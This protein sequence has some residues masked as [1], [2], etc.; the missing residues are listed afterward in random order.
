MKRPAL[1]LSTCALLACGAARSADTATVPFPTRPIRLVVPLTSG[2]I[3]DVMSR[4]LA[5]KLK[6]SLGQAVVVENR[7]GAGTMLA[8]EYVARADADGYTLLM[9]ASSLTI[10]PAVYPKGRV[11][12]DPVRDFAPISLVA[13]VPQVLVATPGL[14]VRTAGELIEYARR[15][16]EQVNYAS[17]GAGTSN[18]LGAEHFN[19]L[20]HIHMKH[21]PYKGTMQGLND[22]VAGHAQVMFADLAAADSFIKAGKLTALG[23]SSARPSP[24]R[25][26]LPAIAQSGLPGFASMSWLGLLAPANTPPQV[27]AR[28]NDAVLKALRSSDVKARFAALNVDLAPSSPEQFKRF[29][30]SDAARWADIA[31]A[32]GASV[33]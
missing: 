27:I 2:G 29:I 24:A 6:D 5:E 3:A 32:T 21:V 11:R 10:A 28:L 7:P 26:Q 12:Y 30:A 22:V 23:L 15:H 25:P 17:S 8:S 13:E 19:Q 4:V 20:A 1:L 18:H 31:R 9:A 33:E 16:P 14:P